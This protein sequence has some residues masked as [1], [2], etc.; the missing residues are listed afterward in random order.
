MN[1]EKFINEKKWSRR[2]SLEFGLGFVKAYL[3]LLVLLTGVLVVACTIPSRLL[4]PQ[5]GEGVEI[6]KSEGI[7][8]SYGFLPWRKILLDNY[9]DALMLNTAL[10]VD[11]K[12]PIWS[13]LTNV[14]H[15][16]ESEIDQISNLAQLYEGKELTR[17][18]YERYW[19]GYLTF[20]RPGLS[21]VSYRG[22]RNFL[23]IMLYGSL[24]VFVYLALKK[25]GLRATLA[26]I[27][28]LMAVDF[29]YLGQSMQFSSVFLM[30]L[31]GAI[32]LLIK[33]KGS[34]YLTFFVVGAVTSFFDLLTAPLVSVGLLLIVSSAR[35]LRGIREIILRV[36]SWFS[37]YGLFWVSKWV[38]VENFYIPG[39]IKTAWSQVINRTVHEVDADFSRVETLRRNIWQL[40]GYDRT[41]KIIILTGLVIFGIFWLRYVDLKKAK[42]SSMASWLL[43]CIIPYGWYLVAAN[44]SYLHVWFTYRNQLMTVVGVFL[45]VTEL[46]NWKKVKK[47]LFWLSDNAREWLVILKN[48]R[49]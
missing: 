26:I 36:A 33:G 29:F 1:D 48:Q 5:M 35:Q 40:I 49:T 17:V 11:E 38:L 45:A 30:G 23:T 15:Q 3:A 20:L 42:L 14:R 2:D 39:A 6:L 10:S 8:P 37:G 7:Y 31:L 9:T 43:I 22:I 28:G 44:H 32:Y 21:I 18:S 46:I 47:D 16:G 24:L 19:H 27:A 12:R 13:S 4:E 25:I 34:E 41:N